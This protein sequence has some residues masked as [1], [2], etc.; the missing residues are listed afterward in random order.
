MMRSNRMGEIMKSVIE[1]EAKTASGEPI[2]R[3]RK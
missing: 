3:L 1:S 2:W